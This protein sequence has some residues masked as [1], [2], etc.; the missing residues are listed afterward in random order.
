MSKYI[1]LTKGYYAIVDDADYES[2]SANKWTASVTK[3]NVYAYRRVRVGHLNYETMTLHRFIMGLRRHDGKI[4]DH[5]NRNG[6]D[7]RREN[8]RIV[9]NYENCCNRR[10][11]R[12]GHKG[13]SF[14]H[15][16]SRWM[17]GIMI[18]K[19]RIN[20]GGYATEDEAARAYDRAA[21]KYQGEFAVLNFPR[22]DY[23][24]DTVSC[25]LPRQ[26][27]IGLPIGVSWHKKQ[28]KY[29]AFA[30]VNRKSIYLGIFN[31]L[32]YAVF[33]VNKFDM[34]NEA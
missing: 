23:D 9:S 30:M 16:D 14:S 32:P 10:A 13:V 19:R 7:N 5:V 22:S 34:L 17:A 31:R 25:K 29:Q 6:L 21:I 26:K 27:I 3:T 24:T 1:P 8:L 15:R 2:V 18:G 4:V 20:L 28:M 12:Q 11:T 33:S